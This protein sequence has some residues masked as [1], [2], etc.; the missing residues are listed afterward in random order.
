MRAKINNLLT[1]DA[2]LTIFPLNKYPVTYKK[3]VWH[4]FSAPLSTKGHHIGHSLQIKTGG[5]QIYSL[6]P[7]AK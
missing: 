6:S 1:F 7:G 4:D 5:R 3:V 2:I